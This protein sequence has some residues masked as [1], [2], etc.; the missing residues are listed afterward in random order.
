[1]LLPLVASQFSF[2]LQTFSIAPKS[3]ARIL[4]Q[5]NLTCF[6]ILILSLSEEEWK[7]WL[8]YA[9]LRWI[10]F[11][12]VAVVQC[13]L[14]VETHWSRCKPVL[15]FYWA[16][17]ACLKIMLF[18]LFWVSWAPFP[19]VIIIRSPQGVEFFKIIDSFIQPMSPANISFHFYLSWDK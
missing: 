15:S 11:Y 5:N 14:L 6:I 19:T 12:H 9:S 13:V 8:L 3:N 18:N 16:L 17:G 10:I 7:R 4:L 1:M 2:S